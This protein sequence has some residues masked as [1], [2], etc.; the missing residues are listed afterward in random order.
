MLLHSIV[1]PSIVAVLVLIVSPAKSSN[2]PTTSE[3]VAFPGALGQGAA[4]L[5]GRGGDVYHVTNLSDYNERKREPETEG[6][7]RYGIQSA[8]GPRTIVFDIGG[9]IRLH[10][11][12]EV[13]R[14][15]LTIAG[16]T[17]PGG[18]TLWGYPF[19]ID[20][21]RHIVVRYIRVRT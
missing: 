2:N 16:Q 7:L 8:N 20:K 3:L 12:L 18:I 15:K 19:N 21:S 14:D 17:A 5:G 10:A 1:R 11:P 6:S 4:A 9:G 13:R